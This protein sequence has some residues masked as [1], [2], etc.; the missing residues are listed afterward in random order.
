MTASDYKFTAAVLRTVADSLEHEGEIIR[1]LARFDAKGFLKRALLI[2]IK[3]VRLRRIIKEM[4]RM[5]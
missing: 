1:E 4:E 3:T 5:E 2:R